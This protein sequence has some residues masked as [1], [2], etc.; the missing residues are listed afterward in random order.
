MAPEIKIISNLPAISI[1]DVAPVATSDAALLAP[2]EIKHKPKGELMSKDERT[3]TDKLRQRR[4]KKLKQRLREKEKLKKE[5]LL[6]KM[7][8]G[9]GNK[10][11]KE[12]AKKM[13][14]KLSKESNVDKMVESQSKAVK[15]S[16]AFFGRLEDEVRSQVKRKANEGSGGAKKKKLIHKITAK[17]IKL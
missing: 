16:S 12:K 13:L 5:K 8:L 14:E 11:S 15:S 9:L 4:Q 2:E 10:Y 7:P 6:S 17:K 1:E 3:T